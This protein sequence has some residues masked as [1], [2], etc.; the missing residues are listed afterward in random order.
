MRARHPWANSRK[1]IWKTSSDCF[2]AAEGSEINLTSK[3]FRIPRSPETGSKERAIM[4]SG[5]IVRQ[6][7]AFIRL[8]KAT[9]LVRT[10]LHNEESQK[11]E[12]HFTRRFKAPIPQ[13]GG[14]A[15]QIRLP[16]RA[17]I[18]SLAPRWVPSWKP[19]LRNMRTTCSRITFRHQ[20]RLNKQAPEAGRNQSQLHQATDRSLNLWLPACHRRANRCITIKVQARSRKARKPKLNLLRSNWNPKKKGKRRYNLRADLSMRIR[21]GMTHK[22]SF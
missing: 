8:L 12:S 7:E 10:L 20:R 3:P 17:R 19:W 1:L 14:K 15:A 22:W 6:Q 13:I 18:T 9:I 2:R 11:R 21:I 5:T 4:M 16:S